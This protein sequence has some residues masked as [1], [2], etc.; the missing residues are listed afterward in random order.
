MIQPSHTP[1][2]IGFKTYRFYVFVQSKE[3]RTDMKDPCTVCDI[4]RDSDYCKQIN[5]ITEDKFLYLKE[6]K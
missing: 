4:G 1:I 3:M 5:C 6:V 2:K